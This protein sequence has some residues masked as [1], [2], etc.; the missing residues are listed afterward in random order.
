MSSSCTQLNATTLR[1]LLCL[2]EAPEPR[3]CCAP[4]TACFDTIC[5]QQTVPTTLMWYESLQKRTSW[6]LLATAHTV[7]GFARYSPPLVQP[8]FSAAS[9]YCGAGLLHG[10]RQLNQQLP[11]TCCMKQSMVSPSS[12]PNCS[13]S[14]SSG[15]N[16]SISKRGQERCAAQSMQQELARVLLCC[17]GH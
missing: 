11:P 8:T 3:R 6:H 4:C 1:S 2:V 12:I 17:W 7:Q 16:S 13:S 14:S 5:W 10:S 9:C 15:N